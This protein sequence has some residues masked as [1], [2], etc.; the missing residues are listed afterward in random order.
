MCFVRLASGCSVLLLETASHSHDRGTQY[1]HL[2]LVAGLRFED[3]RKYRNTQTS[4]AHVPGAAN[5]LSA[6]T[7]VVLEGT[8]SARQNCQRPEEVGAPKIRSGEAQT[9]GLSA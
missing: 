2:F 3:G 7:T 9:W 8:L 1:S 4:G 5:A 6:W